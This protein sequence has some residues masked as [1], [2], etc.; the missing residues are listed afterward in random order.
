LK[1]LTI[2]YS[3]A[4][5]LGL[6]IALH[7]QSYVAQAYTYDDFTSTGINAAL[8]TDLGPNPG[9]FSQPGNG[10]LNFT[11][12]AGGRDILGSTHLPNVPFFVS[13]QYSNFTATYSGTD[14]LGSLLDVWL[15]S[16][17]ENKGVFIFEYKNGGGMGFIADL[18]DGSS[19][20]FYAI[21]PTTVTSGWLGLGYNGIVG[22]GGEVSFWYNSGA[23]WTELATVNPDFASLPHFG[24]EGY[25]QAGTSLSFQVDQVQLLEGQT[26]PVPLPP[27]FFLLGSGLLGLAGWRGFRKF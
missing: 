5:L 11:D 7:I 10:F 2:L 16:Y 14:Y 12:S 3:V 17:S 23:G 24:V 22:P 27:S 6:L 13:M 19:H 25:N 9:V 15:S 18:R 1:K 26:S 8:W 20:T 4:V 21:V